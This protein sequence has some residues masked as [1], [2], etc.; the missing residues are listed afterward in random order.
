[1]GAEI[2]KHDSE[3]IPDLNLNV[4]YKSI[5]SNFDIRVL[6]LSIFIL[7]AFSL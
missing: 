4:K 1:M 5:R 6:I 7:I 3:V 2:L